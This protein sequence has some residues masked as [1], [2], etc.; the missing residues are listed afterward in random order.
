MNIDFN[1]TLDQE[2]GTWQMFNS[3]SELVY[4]C[5]QHSAQPYDTI[6]YEAQ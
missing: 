2:E 6:G 4:K 5:R 3:S 1:Q